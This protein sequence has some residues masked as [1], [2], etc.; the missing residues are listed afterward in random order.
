MINWLM[1]SDGSIFRSRRK[2]PA[3]TSPPKIACP[4]ENGPSRKGRSSGG[5]VRHHY[6]YT[7]DHGSL[8]RLTEVMMELIEIAVHVYP[9]TMEP[10]G[11]AREACCMVA[12]FQEGLSRAQQKQETGPGHGDSGGG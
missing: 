1:R 5:S 3:K 9:S 2:C 7:L 6:V 10:N 4:P 12:R 8:T 11:V